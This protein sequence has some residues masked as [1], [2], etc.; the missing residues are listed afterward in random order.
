MRVSGLTAAILHFALNMM[1][2]SVLP[3]AN[4]S[5]DLSGKIP[6]RHFAKLLN[7]KTGEVICDCVQYFA[8]ANKH[9]SHVKADS[10]GRFKDKIGKTE[11]DFHTKERHAQASLFL[12]MRSCLWSLRPRE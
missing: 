4:I 1:S 9:V 10:P 2:A 6:K 11:F 12:Q 5:S 3:L 8:G 7:L